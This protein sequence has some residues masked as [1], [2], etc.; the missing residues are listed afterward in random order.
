MA[1]GG[2]TT[3]DSKARTDNPSIIDAARPPWQC[4]RHDLRLLKHD[5]RLQE[6]RF[7]I[8]STHPS[9][10]LYES[11][12]VQMSEILFAYAAHVPQVGYSQGMSDMLAVLLF[13][14]MDAPLAFGCFRALVRQAAQLLPTLW[15]A[16]TLRVLLMDVCAAPSSW[17]W[18]WR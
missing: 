17:S 9:H 10:P 3:T 13:E 6:A 5:R 8:A 12:K 15:P 1:M 16:Y 14:L 18:L 4:E 11:C 7:A 2:T